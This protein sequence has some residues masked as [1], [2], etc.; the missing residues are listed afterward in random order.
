M[1]PKYDYEATEGAEIRLLYIIIHGAEFGT[2]GSSILYSDAI[3]DTSR[4]M[5][6]LE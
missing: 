4:K 6:W 3:I 1:Q 2:N 5:T